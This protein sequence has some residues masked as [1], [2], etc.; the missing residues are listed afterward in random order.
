MRICF[1]FFCLEIET[2][3]QGMEQPGSPMGEPGA[4]VFEVIS[5]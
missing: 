5:E 2:G 1:V 4:A 3:F